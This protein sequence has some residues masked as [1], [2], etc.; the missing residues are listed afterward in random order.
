MSLSL[1]GRRIIL[2]IFEGLQSLDLTGPCEVF[3][4]AARLRPGAYEIVV[5]SA[6]GGQVCSSSGLVLETRSL[7][8]VRPGSR[9]T[10]LVVGGDE[11]AIRG[12]IR[13]ERLLRWLRRA[14]SQ[15][16]RLGSVCSGAFVLG[17]AGLLRGR[18][19]AT[20][21]A[22]LDRLAASFPE[23]CVDREAI[24]VNDGAL[25]TSAGVTTGIDMALSMVEHDLERSVADQVAAR[26][27]LYARRPG[28]QTQFADLLAIQTQRGDPLGP[29][30]TWAKTHP[31][32]DLRVEALARKAGLSVRT[33]HRRCVDQLGSTPARL[34][35]RL[36]VDR[37]RVLLGTTDLALKEIAARCGFR[38]SAQLG[39]AFE[40][41]LGVTPR[42]YRAHAASS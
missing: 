31:G 27:V 34:I 1:P 42:V 32:A 29:A 12:A 20:H 19:V 38:D 26:L 39:R 6:A 13:D 9:D 16:E 24:Y 7:R 35:E 11:E 22:A 40:R 4:A 41:V 18:R 25:W 8:G 21:W 28:F 3:A 15:A 2:V 5:A 10:V 14:A 36:R 30:L 17:A 37:G 23:V 33:F